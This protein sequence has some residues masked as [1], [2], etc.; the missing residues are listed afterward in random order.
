[1]PPEHRAW[2]AAAVTMLREQRQGEPI[3]EPVDISIMA[4]WPIAKKRPAWCPRNRWSL[5]HEKLGIP[6]ATKPD[7]DNV[8]KIVIDALVEAGILVDDR[9]VV[10][11][12]MS[13]RAVE[14]VGRV[15]I[16]VTPV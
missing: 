5:R 13:K 6:Y 11:L 16:W 10:D 7:I 15:D 3:A 2:M 12:N 8:G 1:M 9:L 4:Y 14:G